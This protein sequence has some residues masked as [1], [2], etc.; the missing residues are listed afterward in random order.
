MRRALVCEDD[1]AIR[2]LVAMVVGREGFE[3]DVAEDGAAG[4]EKMREGCYDLLLIDL[5][6][7]GVDG[8]AVLSFLESRQPERL[9]RVVVM[10]A[11]AGLTAAELPA[12]VCGILSKPFDIDALKAVVRSCASACR[13][14]EAARPAG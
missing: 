14:G 12:G 5:M 1:A 7:P 10:T 11:A 2:K 13:D 9:A 3:V 8:H 4:M 6:M